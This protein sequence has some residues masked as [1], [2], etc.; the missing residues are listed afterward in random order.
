MGNCRA[1]RK[2]KAGPPSNREL[3][4]PGT[5]KSGKT[6]QAPIS[7][8]P[9][10][11]VVVALWFAALLGFGSLVIP[12]AVFEKLMVATGVASVVESAQPPLG[13]TAR[14]MIALLGAIIGA[15][16]GVFVARKVA[17][18]QN[19]S[20]ALV[21][22]G[23]T[24]AASTGD[25]FDDA[26]DFHDSHEAKRPISAHEELGENG[27][28]APLSDDRPFTSDAPPSVPSSN[29][30]YNGKRRSLAVTDDSG[31]SEYLDHAPLPGGAID[32]DGQVVGQG[33]ETDFEPS[34]PLELA[35][36]ALEDVPVS[37]DPNLQSQDAR[38]FELPSAGGSDIGAD[39]PAVSGDQSS[40]S[41][42]ELRQEFALNREPTPTPFGSAT[43][44]ADSAN[45]NPFAE[46]AGDASEFGKPFARAEQ[47]MPIME[48][49]QGFA[50]PP[51]PSPAASLAVTNLRELSMA[52][53]VER[54]AAALQSKAEADQTAAHAQIAAQV[55]EPAESASPL[56]FR[57][58]NPASETALNATM[59]APAQLEADPDEAGAP[60]TPPPA[61]PEF[62][63]QRQA[64]AQTEPSSAPASIPFAL[65]PFD[66]DDDGDDGGEDGGDDVQ[67]LS[68][69]LRS[70]VQTFGQSANF[71]T[72]SKQPAAPPAAL[73][74]SSP[75]IAPEPRPN[76]RVATSQTM[77]DAPV[78]APVE[79]LETEPHEE[80]AEETAYSSLLNMKSQFSGNQEFVRVEDDDLGESTR[81]PVVVFP[82]QD[83]RRASP[84]PDGPTRDPILAGEP[85]VA[86]QTSRP[87]DGPVF[88]KTAASGNNIGG[89]PSGNSA[90]ETERALREA[91]EKLQRMSGAA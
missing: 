31:P 13:T 60:V 7:S 57:R 23:K 5:K 9:I 28:D 50:P 37:A 15:I 26:G 51:T 49:A 21:A 59:A 52:E 6:K 8:H 81:E 36:L 61:V 79:E 45:H 48:S 18:A 10:F 2:R 91:L 76:P 78:Q 74:A 46:L 72:E 63:P 58:S 53:L 80:N 83:E 73:S 1:L 14:L 82:G 35:D 90:G 71:S 65:R 16:A 34:E 75:G 39:F 41:A 66:Q 25:D 4:V 43:T 40:N 29:R 77:P 19:S 27:L 68:L 24:D 32:F 44:A 54:F 22:R 11:P 62:A 33:F 56:V 89:Q 20:S 67:G 86:A 17:K 47:A 87:F 85:N 30:S 42:D 88:G 84:A 69:T 12:V 64:I 55:E 70:S 3:S 38:P